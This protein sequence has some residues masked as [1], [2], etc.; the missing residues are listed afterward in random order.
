[1]RN[2]GSVEVILSG[3]R[4]SAYWSKMGWFS[5]S[6]IDLTNQNNLAAIGLFL[7]IIISVNSFSLSVN[8]RALLTRI[9]F[10]QMYPVVL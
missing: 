8:W 6:P 1:M 3:F 4:T 5:A 9:T 7:C 10:S 2:T